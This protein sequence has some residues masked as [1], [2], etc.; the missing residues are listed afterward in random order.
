M[1]PFR[2]RNLQDPQTGGITMIVALMLLV[3][4]TVAS[5]AM[6]RN[7]LREIVTSG[8][9]RQGAMA[10]NVA[11]SGIEWSIHWFDLEN[12]KLASNAAANLVHE[13]AVLLMDDTLS[14]IAKDSVTGANYVPG[15]S[16][17]T[18][19]SIPGPTGVTQGF[20]LGLTRMGKLPITGT[21]QGAGPSAYTPASGGPLKQAPDLWA[22]RSDAQVQ[23]GSVTFVHAKEV[24]LST[25]VQ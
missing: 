19:M 2:S 21:S 13:K 22:I 16:L 9:S 7:S 23:Q 5:V 8:F 25:P 4:L 15:G 10:R 14:G 3:L 6:S 1:S 17:Q 18:D 20:T 12:G 11:D 24:W